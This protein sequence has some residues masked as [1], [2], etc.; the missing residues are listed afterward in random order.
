MEYTKIKRKQQQR[1]T[2]ARRA[3]G[4]QEVIKSCRK[5]PTAFGLMS[6]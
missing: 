1:A 3:K 6:R 4:L 2:G 5:L